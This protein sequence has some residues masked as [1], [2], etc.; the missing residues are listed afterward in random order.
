VARR[1]LLG[2]GALALGDAHASG[3]GLPLSRALEGLLVCCLQTGLPTFPTGGVPLS[4]RRAKKICWVQIG[5]QK[6]RVEVPLDR[7]DAAGT[8]MPALPQRFL[9]ILAAAMTELR[10]PGAA[11]GDFE[12]GA[13]RARRRSRFKRSINIPL[14]TKKERSS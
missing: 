12:Q 8:P 13:A 7:P 2:S 10:Q 9:D 4:G 1:G 3:H 6:C 14:R 11:S 5:G